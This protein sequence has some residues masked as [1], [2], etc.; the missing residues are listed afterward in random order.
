LMV[1]ES[2]GDTDTN[3]A[4]AGAMFGARYGLDALPAELVKSVEAS[5]EFRRKGRQLYRMALLR[6]K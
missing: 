6:K 3:A 2:G 4:I 5:E 1:L